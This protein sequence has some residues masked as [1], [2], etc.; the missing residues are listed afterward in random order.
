MHDI[1]DLENAL[2]E[3]YL[4]L[5]LLMNF[6]GERATVLIDDEEIDITH[7]FNAFLRLFLDIPQF[8]KNTDIIMEGLN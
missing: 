6:E 4:I 2:I 8:E 3:D 7:C 1:D 5:N